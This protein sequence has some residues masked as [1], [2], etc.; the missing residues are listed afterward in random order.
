MVLAE[1]RTLENKNAPLRSWARV[2]RRKHCLPKESQGSV[3]GGGDPLL[4][5]QDST[6]FKSQLGHLL[7]G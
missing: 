3:L 5:G 6:G 2:S 4:W 1:E 7:T